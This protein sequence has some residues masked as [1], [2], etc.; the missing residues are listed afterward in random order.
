MKKKGTFTFLLLFMHLCFTYAQQITTDSSLQ[1][2]QLIENLTSGS[3]A[4]AT[5]ASSSIN[6]IVNNIQSFGFF[7][8]GTSDFPLESGI[9]LS[10]GN[11]N[12]AGNTLI[13]ESLSDGNLDWETDPDIQTILGIDQTLNATSLEFDFTSVNNSLSFKYVFASD[14]YQQQYPCNFQDVFAI[15]IKEAGTSDP[16]VNIAL[17]PDSSNIVSTSSIHPEIPNGCSA[18]NVDFFEGYNISTTNF[19]GQ[20][21]VLNAN[22]DITPGVLYRIKFVIADHID[23]RFDSAVFI[24]SEGFGSTVD[25]GPDQTACG[26]SV[27]LDGAIDNNQAT[28]K[29]FKDGEEII[30]Q[31]NTTLPVIEY[32]VYVVEVNIPLPNGSC[33]MTDSV[34]I[35]TIPFQQAEPILDIVV[36]DEIPYDGIAIF[37]LTSKNDEI[38]QNLP[39]TNFAISYHL[40]QEEAL[41]DLNPISGDYENTGLSE[42]IYVRIES[43]DGSCL[44]LGTF[45]VEVGVKPNYNIIAPIVVC[46]DFVVN[47]VGYVELAY[48]AFEIANY[49][50]NRT[51]T[52]HTTLEDAN[53]GINSITY[54]TDVPF[55]SNF[56]FARIVNDF[57]GCFTVV[58]IQV[59]V[60]DS[61][62]TSQKLYLDLC[63]PTSEGTG[64]FDLEPI[65]DEVLAQ[66]PTANVFFYRNYDNALEGSLAIFPGFL[67][68]NEVPYHQTIYMGVSQLNQPCVSII[69]IDLHT[70][71]AFNI[72]NE[73]T[74]IN[75]CDDNSNDNILDF[76]LIDVT[77]ELKEGYDINILYYN[78]DE[79]RENG[80]NP[81]NQ[82][83]PYTATSPTQT[84]YTIVSNDGCDNAVNISLKINP[85]PE[86]QPHVLEYCGNPNI[87][88]GYTTIQLNPLRSTIGESYDNST[89]AL[90]ATEEDA[91]IG[92]NTIQNSYDVI[93][94]NPILYVRVTNSTTQ[95][96]D[97]TTLQVNLS[98]GIAI[99][100]P[101]PIIICNDDLD[102]S[103][104]V[105]LESV[106]PQ[107]SNDLSGT[108]ISFYDSY[109]AAERD[110]LAILNPESYTTEN[111]E[112][113][114]R[115]YIEGLECFV[116]VSFDVLI[117]DNPQISVVSDFINCEIDININSA[118]FFVNKDEEIIN[119]QEGMQVLYFENETDAI[120]R[121]NSIDK[122]VAYSNTSNPQTIYVRLENE[123]EN[124]C[125]KTAPIQIEA[126]QAPIYIEPTDIFACDYNGNGLNTVDFSEK[127]DEIT[128]GATQ[129]LNVTFHLSPLN[130]SLGTNP[131]PLNYTT[132]IN[133]Q[134]I[135]A[136]IENIATSCFR[137]SNFNIN[138][139]ALPEVNY[140][141]SLVNCGN[142][143]EFER[144]WDLTDIE[145]LILE[146]RQYGI[147]F[148]YFESEEDLITDT[149]QILNPENYTNVSQPQTLFVKVKNVSTECFSTVPF[150][151]ILNSPPIINPIATYNT[152]EN[153]DSSLNLLD[154]NEV[155][156][157]D[158][159]NILISY[160]PSEEDAEANQ[161][162]L[163]PDYNYSNTVE[164]LFVRA[165]YSTTHC[166]A[167]YPF[168]LVVNPL[169]IAYQPNDLIACDDD[170]DT[171]LQFDLSIQNNAVLNGQ[172][173]DDFSVSYFN[174]ENNANENTEQLN[175]NYLA[176]DS[177]IIFVR[178]EDNTT[179]CYNINEFSVVV[180]SLPLAVIDNKVICLNNL[181]LVVSADT[182]NPTDQ[183]L[184]STNAT[185]TEIEI[186]ETGTYFVTIT[187]QFGCENTSTFN[188]TESDSA[189]I[190]VVETIDFSDPNNIV[191]SVNGIGDYLYQL[192]DG[193]F[194]SSNVFQNVP[195]GYNTITIIDQNGCAQVTRE[196]LVVDTPKHMSPNDDGDFDTWHIVGVETLPGTIIHIFDRYGKLLKE[197][198]SNTSGWDGT[199]NG[200]KMP[201]GDYWFV[202]K[203]IDSKTY[204]GHFSLRR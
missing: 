125:F 93:G 36:C 92:E 113:F 178:V 116:I 149:N 50:F 39:S 51:V 128:N 175:T 18:E 41:D 35:D 13:S 80:T 196:V 162:A 11:V 64:L 9:V 4:A 82:N 26:S 40:S 15:L 84:L 90:Y 71:L 156:F 12:S 183:Y 85:L 118:F 48:Y 52:F 201:S 78:T 77:N 115:V 2:Q 34:T 110:R 44:Q 152:C 6:G 5:N 119:G 100:K 57:S 179:G 60:L 164:T 42:I 185:S 192:N 177:E 123:Q 61:I 65:R 22:T 187:N 184:W 70:N 98:D 95:C 195:L 59:Q 189:T 166:Y 21:I 58:P 62:D 29:W 134:L 94:D 198:G 102:G 81:I 89:I 54:A 174:S 38:M 66:F 111:T 138:T 1:P 137:V 132:I 146:G 107:L 74:V 120:N 121:E 69:E 79:D 147:E 176:Y 144:L 194:Q 109:N 108:N 199:Y 72:V 3:C 47:G 203:F 181:P 56:T 55:G 154:I 8:R 87:E 148:T 96:Y 33:T 86:V 204:T 91:L 136:R 30:G 83:I 150:S 161:N 126:R 114:I 165:E 190:D 31:T 75:R 68:Q 151:L 106:I 186:F 17:L 45:N 169:P 159:Y 25:L 117:Y 172:N 43:L 105:N 155:L 104:T 197:L 131:L 168:Q 76:D 160:H 10:T 28:Y 173:P 145:L 202:V 88:A 49:E 191:V 37:D 63:L 20:T 124:S 16:Y 163:N 142:N 46:S 7:N 135:H 99:A 101:E 182:N 167:V 67:Y 53:N 23:Q 103:A 122:T 19:D 27:I 112:I 133:P 129:E 170:F 141:Q 157:D 97:I 24:E 14:E 32:G 127:I 153:N 139:L 158:T 73:R 188:V 143:Y 130:A 193:P 200:N 140:D 180:N 171:F